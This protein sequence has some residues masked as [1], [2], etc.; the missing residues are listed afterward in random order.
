MLTVANL[1]HLVPES[2][3]QVRFFFQN[4]IFRNFS[5]LNHAKAGFTFEHGPS[6]TSAPL[7]ELMTTVVIWHGSFKYVLYEC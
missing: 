7:I 6:P 5:K 1:K 3:R 2:A 4:R